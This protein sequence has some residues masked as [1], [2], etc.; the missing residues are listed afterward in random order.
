MINKAI[1]I[2]MFFHSLSYALLCIWNCWLSHFSIINH[3]SNNTVFCL[4]GFVRVSKNSVSG[5][6]PVHNFKSWWLHNSQTGYMLCIL[7]Y[8]YA[9]YMCIFFLKA[10][11]RE[12]SHL[13]RVTGSKL[14]NIRRLHYIH[15]IYQLTFTIKKLAY[16]ICITYVHISSYKMF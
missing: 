14:V 12:F 6:L 9:Y 3:S 8:M 2:I 7:G 10:K 1:S 4:H 16:Y 11:Q 5:G 15:M 13:V